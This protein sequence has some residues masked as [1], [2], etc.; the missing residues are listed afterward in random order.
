MSRGDVGVVG[1][2]PVEH[3][4]VV[5]DDHVA[6]R[7]LVAVDAVG[8]GRPGQQV[9]EQRPALV[10]VHAHDVVGGGARARASFRPRACAATRGGAPW[11][12][13]VR[14]TA[15]SSGVRVV[16]EQALRRLDGVHHPHRRE[17]L[18]LVVGQVVVG[19]V[20]AG[21]LGLAP[22]LG[23]GVGA[24]HRGHDRDVVGAAVDVPVEGA[25]QVGGRRVLLR[26]EGDPE[27][28]GVLALAE[29]L[30][31][32]QLLAERD[33]GGVVDVEVAEHERA[34]GLERL[35]ARGGQRRRRAAAARVSTPLTSAPTVAP[36]FSV[37]ITAMRSSTCSPVR[38]RL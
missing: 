30:D 38:A 5:P 24:Q 15:S 33:L 34:V 2:G 32:A 12:G 9:V 19:G 31:L 37:V 10:G 8:G 23:H 17:P 16:V 21:E 11:R 6:D 7:P 1:A 18:L 3:A 13:A 29:D 14:Q 22:G 20:G 27:D 4:A 26:V 25:A 28:L 36:S 35:E